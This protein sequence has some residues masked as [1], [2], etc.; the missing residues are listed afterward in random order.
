MSETESITSTATAELERSARFGKQLTNHLGRK[1]GGEWNGET[2]R[3]WVTLLERHATF[4]A[5]TGTLRMQVSAPAD[6]LDRLERVIGGHLVRFVRDPELTVTWARSN[7]D[8]G[9]TQRFE[10]EE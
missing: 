4:T 2:E 8:A 10:S 6:E 5:S 3:G 9:S 7:G 1:Q